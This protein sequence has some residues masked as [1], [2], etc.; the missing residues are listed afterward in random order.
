MASGL[1]ASLRYLALDERVSAS[2]ST[3]L[4]FLSTGSLLTLSLIL[5]A[6]SPEV[7]LVLL[8]E[9]VMLLSTVP[10]LPFALCV[11]V[12]P[13][14][15]EPERLEFDGEVEIDEWLAVELIDKDLEGLIVSRFLEPDP[16]EGIRGRAEG[17]DGY[18]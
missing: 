11:A 2:A 14:L 15:A 9:V 17:G 7:L 13:S 12:L 5:F 10:A 18:P 6:H 3:A 4:P 8:L 16:L 1:R